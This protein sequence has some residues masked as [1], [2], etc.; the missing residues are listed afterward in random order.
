M[1]HSVHISLSLS[2]FSGSQ[3][4]PIVGVLHKIIVYAMEYE[5]AECRTNS[6]ESPVSISIFSFLSFSFSL[7]PSTHSGINP[8][9]ISASLQGA[10]DVPRKIRPQ[11]G[12]FQL[13]FF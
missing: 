7:S 5:E 4:A 12:V 6:V 9:L 8:I 1:G 2:L 10:L 13:H 3:F 11:F